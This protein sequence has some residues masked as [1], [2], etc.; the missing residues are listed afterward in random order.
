MA[1]LG[2]QWNVPIVYQAPLHWR[3]V[4]PRL[5]SSVG[6]LLTSL[7]SMSRLPAVAFYCVP[8]RFHLAH[9]QCS[10]QLRSWMFVCR[11]QGLAPF[12]AAFPCSILSLSERPGFWF[13]LSGQQEGPFAWESPPGP[14]AWVVGISTHVFSFFRG[15]NILWFQLAVPL[16]W[17]YVLSRICHCYWQE[18]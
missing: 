5:S 2:F 8:W 12:S 6:Q 15:G 10:S 7:L 9:V 14:W 1:L 16:Q 17:F 11:Y 13:W 18:G 4:H 3:G